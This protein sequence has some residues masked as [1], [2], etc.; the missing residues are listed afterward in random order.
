MPLNLLVMSHAL[1]MVVVKCPHLSFV[2]LERLESLRMGHWLAK[3]TERACRTLVRGLALSGTLRC[4][5]HAG[6]T[7]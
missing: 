6:I 2:R 5:M 1:A 4:I 7:A 3:V